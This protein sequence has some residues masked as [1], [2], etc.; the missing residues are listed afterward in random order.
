MEQLQVWLLPQANE[1]SQKIS[2]NICELQND[3]CFTSANLTQESLLWPTLT[4][5]RQKKEFQEI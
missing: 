4:G 3:C 2:N 1:V 5:N